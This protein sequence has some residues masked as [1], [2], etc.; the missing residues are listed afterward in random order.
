MANLIYKTETIN[1]D[2]TYD[3]MCKRGYSF[4]GRKFINSDI[5]SVICLDQDYRL[6]RWQN[7][8][9]AYCVFQNCDFRGARFDNMLFQNCI[10]KNCQFSAAYFNRGFFKNCVHHQTIL[11]TPDGFKTLFQI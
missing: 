9:V 2:R 10:F 4:W 7:G 11:I 1:H 6:S 3:S 5:Y 8:L